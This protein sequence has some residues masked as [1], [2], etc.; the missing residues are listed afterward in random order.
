MGSIKKLFLWVNTQDL[1]FFKHLLFFLIYLFKHKQNYYLSQY[2]L[3]VYPSIRIISKIC[4]QQTRE[5]FGIFLL[6]V[7]F[8]SKAYIWILYF[9]A[10]FLYTIANKWEIILQYKTTKF[11]SQI[12][13]LKIILQ[14]FSH[15]DIWML[16][17]V[18]SNY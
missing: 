2:S 9:S 16:S 18:K 12:E 7:Y 15:M 13:G 17:C 11:E 5:A 14:Y 4:L 6:R 1:N 10:Y 3:F 8:E